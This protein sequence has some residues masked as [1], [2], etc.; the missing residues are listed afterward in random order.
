MSLRFVWQNERLNLAQPWEK[1][2]FSN[3]SEHNM[4]VKQPRQNRMFQ[5]K[6]RIGRWGEPRQAT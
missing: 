6:K 4:S 2:G 3:L 5:Q 1:I